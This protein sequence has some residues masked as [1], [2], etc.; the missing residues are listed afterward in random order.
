[1]FGGSG[2]GERLVAGERDHEVD[3]TTIGSARRL[4]RGAA[5]RGERR[6]REGSVR[7]KGE[8]EG[9]IV[10]S[11]RR[12]AAVRLGVNGQT[13]R[14]LGE[15]AGSEARQSSR[16]APGAGE[17]YG[18]PPGQAQRAIAGP[19]IESLGI[20]TSAPRRFGDAYW[21]DPF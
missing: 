2:E 17:S 12:W 19:V 6:L 14:S 16:G 20:H 18:V 13:A 7:P 3:G 15:R 9:A 1:L 5:G 21:H 8:L 11:G 10:D 4:K